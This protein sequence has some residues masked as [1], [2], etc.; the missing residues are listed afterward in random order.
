MGDEESI[1]GFETE[2]E[3]QLAAMNAIEKNNQLVDANAQGIIFEQDSTD[4]VYTAMLTI[5]NPLIVEGGHPPSLARKAIQE[6]YDGVICKNVVDGQVPSDIYVVFSDEQIR[7]IYK[8][9]SN[10]GNWY[11]SAQEL[12]VEQVEDPRAKFMEGAHPSLF[13]E[14]GKPITTYHGTT[15]Q[16]DVF[17]GGMGNKEGH[18]GASNY[19]TNERMDAYTNYGAEGSDLEARIGQESEMVD[20]IFEEDGIEGVVDTYGIDIIRKIENDKGIK[21]IPNDDD[22]PYEFDLGEIDDEMSKEIAQS[23]L[24]GPNEEGIVMQ[25]HIRLKNPIIKGLEEETYFDYEQEYDEE[26]DEYGEES[27]GVIDLM[28]AIQSVA[29]EYVYVDGMGS[30]SD[31]NDMWSTI[32]EN[33]EYYEGF[34]VSEFEKV[35]RENFTTFRGDDDDDSDGEFLRKVYEE[36]GYDG[37]IMD[38]NKAFGPQ[39]IKGPYGGGGGFVTEGMPEM[40]EGVIHYLVFDPKAIKSSERSGYNPESENIYETEESQLT[41]S[42]EFRM[43]IK[44]IKG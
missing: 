1:G 40:Y 25:V 38:A 9:A 26:S 11:K 5:K 28:E 15:W 18:Y 4:Q 42:E 36:M 7:L 23:R 12:P 8:K 27:G 2:E 17:N 34:S 22:D 44:N 20:R 24:I 31:P 13:E 19:F 14:G 43:K 29:G 30:S 37:I 6:G 39:H 41:A 35:F 3:A 33:L 32:S 16:F 21:L 10:G